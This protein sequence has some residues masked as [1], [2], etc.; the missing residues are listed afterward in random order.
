[1]RPERE[2]VVLSGAAADDAADADAAAV[3]VLEFLVLRGASF[4][5]SAMA[6]LSLFGRASE[7]VIPV[8]VVYG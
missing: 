8:V 5:L 1:M 2:F 4:D 3:V 7:L 6:L